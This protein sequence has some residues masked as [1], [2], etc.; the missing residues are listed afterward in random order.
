MTRRR[1]SGANGVSNTILMAGGYESRYSGFAVYYPDGTP[2]QRLGVKIDVSV[3]LTIQGVL[4][5][6]DEVLQRALLFI[7]QQGRLEV[8]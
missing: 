2:N 8:A 7:E 1:Y 4:S 6:Q 5:G 3:S